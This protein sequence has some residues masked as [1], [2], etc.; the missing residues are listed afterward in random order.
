MKSPNNVSTSLNIRKNKVVLL[1]LEG[2]P[3]GSGGQKKKKKSAH[4]VGDPGLIPGSGRTPGSGEGNG[5][6]L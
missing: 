4:N 1:L 2:F 3:G 6:L 5:N